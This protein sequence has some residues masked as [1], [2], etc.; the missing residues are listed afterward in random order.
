MY[1]TRPHGHITRP[2]GADAQSASWDDQHSNENEDEDNGLFSGLY[3]DTESDGSDEDDNGILI[4][5]PDN[6]ES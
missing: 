5:L 1:W 6:F 3:H 4:S 2:I